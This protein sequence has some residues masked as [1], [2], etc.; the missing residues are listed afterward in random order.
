MS[1]KG[2]AIGGAVGS[3]FGP[4]G[5]M[6]GMG[7]G[8]LF[9]AEGEL[10]AEFGDEVGLSAR[11]SPG[12]P[13]LFVAWE[14]GPRTKLGQKASVLAF[15]RRPDGTLVKS[16]AEGYHTRGGDAA[17]GATFDPPHGTGR[18]M[19]GEIDIPV[20]AVLGLEGPVTLV[21]LAYDATVPG[22]DEAELLAKQEYSLNWPGDEVLFSNA[23]ESLGRFFNG[24]ARSRGGP[25]EAEATHLKELLTKVFELEPFG[26][27][28]ADGLIDTSLNDP[29]LSIDEASRLLA[30]AL[31]DDVNAESVAE[32]V[33]EFV[34]IHP[35]RPFTPP[36]LPRAALIGAGIPAPV[37]DEVRQRVGGDD[38]SAHL[39]TL[40]LGHEDGWP[41]VVAAYRRLIR[42]YH[43]DTVARMPKAFRDLAHEKTVELNRAYAALK[44]RFGR[45]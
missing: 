20:G 37:V 22:D 4:L 12:G 33:W 18:Q 5:T 14:L 3:M 7:I 25:D 21:L 30:S 39:A 28:V 42:E 34:A 8:H 32:I 44:G 9:D 17:F 38:I 43:P 2:K 40:E 36:D 45:V 6:V 31:P 1:W 23:L 15:L 24:L 11:V 16:D 29:P 13:A 35:D 19:H 41:E 26:Q 27:A 10:V